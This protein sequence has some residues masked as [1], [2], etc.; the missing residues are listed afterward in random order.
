M[1][2]PLFKPG[3]RCCCWVTQLCPTLWPQGLQPSRIF[4]P[5]SSPGVCSNSC[6][7]S[8]WY[9]LIISSSAALFSFCLQ[10]F[11][12]SGSFPMSHLFTSGDQIIAASASV[13]PMNIQSWLPTIAKRY[14]RSK[15][16]SLDEWINQMW[17]IRTMKYISTLKR[18]EILTYATIHKNLEDISLS[19]IR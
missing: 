8:W 7:M 15:Y 12:A 5:P 6:P 13:L 17:Y 9:Y 14:K 11:P 10:S 3:Y 19:K 4:C 1:Q 16:S 18:N 2:S